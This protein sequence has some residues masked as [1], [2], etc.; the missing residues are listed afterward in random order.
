MKQLKSITLTEREFYEAVRLYVM[1]E[2][3]IVMPPDLS[4]ITMRECDQDR[5]IVLEWVEKTSP[6]SQKHKN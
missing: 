3:N 1:E 5:T 2:M 6:L 4:Q